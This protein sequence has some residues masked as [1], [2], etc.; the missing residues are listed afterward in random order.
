[1]G[2][3][4]WRSTIPSEPSRFLWCLRWVSLKLFALPMLREQSWRE[5]G[6]DVSSRRP[7]SHRRVGRVG[8]HRFGRKLDDRY[9]W[10]VFQAVARRRAPEM[11]TVVEQEARRR[12]RD[13]P[14]REV[15]TSFPSGG[16]RYASDL[17]VQADK[18]VL[19]EIESAQRSGST[20]SVLLLHSLDEPAQ[21]YWAAKKLNMTVGHCG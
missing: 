18:E 12:Q 5:T 2:T 4:E 14:G 11:D 7:P 21:P 10:R 6:I 3:F 19:T 8:Q 15:D 9:P 1:M 17:T 13:D 16:S 20:A